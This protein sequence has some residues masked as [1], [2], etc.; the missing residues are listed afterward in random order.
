LI[1]DPPVE[2][3]EFP[4][5][6]GPPDK[7]PPAGRLQFWLQF[8]PGQGHLPT[9]KDDPDL[10]RRMPWTLVDQ[11]FRAFNPWVL[12]SSPRR[13]TRLDLICCVSVLGRS[14]ADFWLQL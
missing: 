11:R 7:G 13:P 14:A 10:R 6:R 12:G 1:V 2:L 3:L 4:A 8:T 9:F 5:G